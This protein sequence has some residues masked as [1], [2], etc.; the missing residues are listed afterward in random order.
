MANTAG[1][2]KTRVQRTFGDEAGSQVTDAD[3]YRWIN[4][5]QREIAIA[6]DLLQVKGTQNVVAAQHDYT[7]PNDILKLLSVKYNGIA[8]RAITMQEAD[9]LIGSIDQSNVQGYPTGTPTHYWIFANQINFY[10]SPDA[11]IVGGITIYYIKQPTDVAADNDALSTPVEY[12]NRI[13]EYCLSLAY[14]M[15]ENYD[16]A[17][18]KLAQFK[19]GVAELSGNEAWE[20]QEFYPHITSL[21]DTAFADYGYIY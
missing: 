7:L 14:E 21:P 9:E 11:A 10:P 16:A 13:V 2:V 4:D 8:L 18:Q 15:D 17:N 19:S 5:A 20:Q 3:V 6:N 12:F 1:D